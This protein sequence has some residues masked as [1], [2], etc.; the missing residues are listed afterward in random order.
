MMGE[1]FA[2]SAD[3]T[4]AVKAVAKVVMTAAAVIEDTAVCLA[5]WRAAQPEF[6]W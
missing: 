1:L 3:A 2:V 4:P 6:L 5:V